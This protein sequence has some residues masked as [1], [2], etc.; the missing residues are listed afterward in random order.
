MELA[1]LLLTITNSQATNKSIRNLLFHMSSSADQPGGMLFIE[2][3]NSERQ[4]YLGNMADGIKLLNLAFPSGFWQ[5]SQH[6][7][8]H[9]YGVRLLDCIYCLL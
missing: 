2:T 8:E 9:G 3:S 5:P 7:V 6:G 1:A 4:R